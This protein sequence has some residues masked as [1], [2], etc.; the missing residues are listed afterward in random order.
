[1]HIKEPAKPHPPG[2]PPVHSP[3]SD[4][5][6]SNVA[7]EA[8]LSGWVQVGDGQTSGYLKP[9]IKSGASSVATRIRQA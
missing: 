1:M 7:L 8:G 5:I 2:T 9:K 6:S 3:R 4:S